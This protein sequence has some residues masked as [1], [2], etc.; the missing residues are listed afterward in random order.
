MCSRHISLLQ[1]CVTSLLGY[2]RCLQEIQLRFHVG[3]QAGAADETAAY[4]G[5]AAY[6]GTALCFQGGDGAG[7]LAW[8]QAEP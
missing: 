5:T 3:N 8:A 7:G 2:G 4:A 6:T 1:Q